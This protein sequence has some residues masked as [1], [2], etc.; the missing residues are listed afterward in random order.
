[1]NYYSLNLKK[2]THEYRVDICGIG[3]VVGGKGGIDREDIDDEGQATSRITT[4]VTGAL[5]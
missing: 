4:E 1:M 5:R 3:R 2:D